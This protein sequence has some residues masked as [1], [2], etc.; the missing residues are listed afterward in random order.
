MREQD[1]PHEAEPPPKL[2]QDYSEVQDWPG[3]FGAVLGKPARD[4]LLA[5]I[6]MFREEERD[7]PP[8]MRR[9]KHWQLFHVVAKRS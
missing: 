3:Y 8:D 9:P 7:D 1:Q 4:T 2:A 5:A 6:E